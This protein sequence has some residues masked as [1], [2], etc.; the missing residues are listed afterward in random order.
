MVRFAY[1]VM[2]DTCI[3]QMPRMRKQFPLS[4]ISVVDPSG[5][6]PRTVDTVTSV[7]KGGHN[8]HHHHHHHHHYHLNHVHNSVACDDSSSGSSSN[9]S[10]SGTEYSGAQL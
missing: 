7:N 10:S 1:P 5:E 9:S 4:F 8:A 6:I 3:A 2:A